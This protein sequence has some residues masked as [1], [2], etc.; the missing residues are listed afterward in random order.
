CKNTY[1]HCADIV[2]SDGTAAMRGVKEALGCL[3]SDW[4][5]MGLQ[6]KTR[7]RRVMLGRQARDSSWNLI[8]LAS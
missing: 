3:L 5:V 1:R 8:V 2:K 6:C 4:L 7:H